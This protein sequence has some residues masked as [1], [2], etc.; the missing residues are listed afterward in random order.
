MPPEP[1]LSNRGCGRLVA[2]FFLRK[3][4]RHIFLSPGAR[5]APLT[6]AFAELAPELIVTHFDERGMGFCALGAA[7][8]SGLPSV[9]IVTSGTAVANLLPAVIEADQSEIPLVL[10]TADRPAWLRGTGSN[11]TILQPGIFGR[12]VRYARDLPIPS[13][14]G[15]TPRVFLESALAETLQAACGHH[16]GPVHLNFQ[17][18]EPLLVPD[19]TP[20]CTPVSSGVTPPTSMARGTAV[21]PPQEFFQAR[22]GVIVL[23]QMPQ[24]QHASERDSVYVLAD[25]L[26]WPVLADGLSGDR[27]DAR[28]ISHADLLL[29]A[30]SVPPPEAVLHL[31]SRLV[32]KRL[33]AWISQCPRGRYWQVRETAGRID[34]HRVF[35]EV[36]HA[37][38]RAWCAAAISQITTIRANLSTLRAW[39][40][41]DRKVSALLHRLLETQSLSEPLAVRIVAEEASNLGSPL[42]LGNS[43][44]VRDF[45]IFC[46][47]LPKPPSIFSNRGASGIDGNIATTAG[48]GIGS[49]T[50]PLALL[51]DL[52]AL[53]D[54]NSLPLLVRQNGKL[55]VLNNGGGGIFQFLPLDLHPD[56]RERFL[57]TPHPFRFDHAAA[58]F[59]MR[60]SAPVAPE[61]LR[62]ALRTSG[63]GLI[64]VRT[65]RTENRALHERIERDFLASGIRPPT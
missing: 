18:D 25:R 12:A 32:S 9:C 53:H 3:G 28:A 22:R 11:Q 59:G 33:M 16:A 35:P 34:P 54:L 51:G 49:N 37:E 57:E 52:A 14:M 17:F 39:R 42:L 5:S 1:P 60:Y 8:A 10:L 55:I 38:P 36:I 24:S 41:A 65:D 47:P 61:C 56:L 7:L 27:G 48:I 31:G 44:P 4:V 2:A 63:P 20:L 15:V 50:P 23:G 29:R 19:E 43:M 64:E 6:S 46:G 30:P 62:D 58:Q 45:S 26:G 13:K 40:D 21:L